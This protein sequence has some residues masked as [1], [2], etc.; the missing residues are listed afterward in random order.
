MICTAHFPPRLPTSFSQFPSRLR[1]DHS[2]PRPELAA[3]QGG[4]RPLQPSL[5]G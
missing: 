1:G 3:L 2:L 5:L 4:I